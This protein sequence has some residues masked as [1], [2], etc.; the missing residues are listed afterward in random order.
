MGS[1]TA[2]YRTLQCLTSD[3]CLAVKQ[4][5]IG[6]SGDLFADGFITQNISED[7]RNSMHSKEDRAARLIGIVQDKVREGP[8]NYHTFISVLK[9]RDQTQYGNILSSLQDT[10]NQGM[11]YC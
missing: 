3:L 2:E 7:L 5:L 11:I 9:K 1:N 10:Y 4:D 8:C 6:L